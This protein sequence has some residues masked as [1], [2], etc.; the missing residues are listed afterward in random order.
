MVPG[1]DRSPCAR[2]G[3]AREL[4]RDWENRPN[5]DYED[6]AVV[7]YARF[8]YEQSRLDG[9]AQRRFYALR[10]VLAELQHLVGN[11][12]LPLGIIGSASNQ[13]VSAERE[14][15]RRDRAMI[16]A[17]VLCDMPAEDI[18]QELGY[19]V[20]TIEYFEYLAWDVRSRLGSRSYIHN[21]VLRRGV[22]NS[23]H[24]EDFEML[25]L[26]EA[27]ANGLES[28]QRFLLISQGDI[29]EATREMARETSRD[30]A[31]KAKLAVLQFRPTSHTIPE[32]INGYNSFRKAD[33]DIQTKEMGT[34]GGAAA[35]AVATKQTQE[36][37]AGVVGSMN[38]SIATSIVDSESDKL[39]AEERSTA[40]AFEAALAAVLSK[41]QPEGV[42]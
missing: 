36:Y 2:L 28:L 25:W 13:Q 29:G 26:H 18:A 40:D 16:K 24:H 38:L 42:S 19:Q 37:V 33:V 17:Y 27:Y 10:P 31:Q 12:S 35:G 1:L 5:T 32:L 20:E 15:I 22:N 30:F 6:E 39:P 8:L 7:E 21:Y 41:A 9:S 11:D 3:R 4:Y 34:G 14:G 23:I